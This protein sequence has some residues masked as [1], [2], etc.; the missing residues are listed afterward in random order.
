M[1]TE[2]PT[3]AGVVPIVPTPFTAAEEIDHEAV[4]RCVRFAA[5]SGLRVVC[6]PAY[7]SEFYKLSEAER[8][9]VIETAVRA[10]DGKVAVMAQANHPSA[11]LAAELARLYESLGAGFISFALPRIFPLPES[12]LLDY[13]ATIC[14]ATKLTV[15]IQDFNPGGAT[16]GADFARRLADTCP[17][18]GYLKLEEP[19]MGGKVRQII[20]ATQGRVGVL[21][22]WGGMYLLDLIP[23][24]IC[25]LMPG[26]GISDLLAHVW[27]AA[28]AHRESE[29]TEIFQVLLPQIV[30][31]LQHSEL[32]NWIEK[33]LLLAR[34]VLPASSTH[35]RRA[36][37]T[38]DEATL[39][40]G[41]LLNAAVVALAHRLGSR[42]G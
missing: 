24:G 35:V 15:L 8:R 1:P 42:S 30:Y 20:D 28:R 19:L 11:K 38:P 31:S 12:D 32:F 25:G 26:L 10:A 21:E 17:N 5:A 9:G 3:L 41:D 18:F 23:A 39:R 27:Q 22:G 29:A 37:W 33:R 34:G 2:A 13:A 16:V 4:G 7:A 14:R 40:H 36:T 6:L